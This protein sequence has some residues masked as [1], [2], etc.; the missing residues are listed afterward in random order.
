MLP[1]WRYSH[2]PSCHPRRAKNNN[3]AVMK[4]GC[5]LPGRGE[6]VHCVWPAG[7]VAPVAVC[8]ALAVAQVLPVSQ[9][10]RLPGQPLVWLRRHCLRMC[11][12]CC[13]Y[14]PRRVPVLIKLPQSVEVVSQPFPRPKIQS[15]HH[16]RQAYLRRSLSDCH[17]RAFQS[18]VFWSSQGLCVLFQ[19][20]W[21]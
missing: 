5:R 8:R 11:Q 17:H 3:P 4:T 10:L 19:P 18:P 15:D 21:L 14:P 6:R 1:P 12:D 16:C 20:D 13:S 9:P 7:V 2:S